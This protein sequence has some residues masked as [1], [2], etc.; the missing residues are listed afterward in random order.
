[1]STTG[2]LKDFKNLNAGALSKFAK[3][4]DPSMLK[5]LNPLELAVRSH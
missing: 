2:V 5:N 3:L 4:K 1:M